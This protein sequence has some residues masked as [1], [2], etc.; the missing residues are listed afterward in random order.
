MKFG[1]AIDS[2]L[3]KNYFNLEGKASRSEYWWFMLFFIIFNFVAGI[4]VGI[5][6]GISQ[7]ADFNPDSF[8]L[9][10]TLGLLALFILP[11]LG[12][13]VRR[14]ADAGRG[15]R[16]AI[17]VFVLAI[18]S[19]LIVPMGAQGAIIQVAEFLI[20]PAWIVFG[21]TSLYTLYIALKKSV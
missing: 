16:E 21:A 8:A 6:V 11:L 17:V 12:L 14:F 5:I 20:M 1:Q 7:G 10:Y 19:Q 3:F 18:I 4:I 9:Y 13:S 15:R 2:V